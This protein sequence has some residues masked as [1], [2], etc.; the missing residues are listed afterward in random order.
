MNRFDD[1]IVELVA[2]ALRI[3]Q[4]AKQLVKLSEGL[5]ERAITIAVATADESARNDPGACERPVKASEEEH[6]DRLGDFETFEETDGSDRS[7]GSG[8]DEDG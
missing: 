6:D 7:S 3:E 2:A 5:Y 8:F 4:Y 1:R